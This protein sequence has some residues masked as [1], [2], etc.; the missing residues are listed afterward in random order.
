M[1]NKQVKRWAQGFLVFVLVVTG[2]API[3]GLSSIAY[4][5]E[6]S[7]VTE[8]PQTS[9]K[10]TS[11]PD[12]VPTEES[13]DLESPTHEDDDM[14]ETKSE[15]PAETDN[16]EVQEADGTGIISIADARVLSPN[17]NVAVSGVVTYSEL[18]GEFT[19][20]YIQDEEAGIVVRAKNQ[21]DVG[22]RIEV[23]GPITHYSGLVQ[24][25]KDKS[26]F[27]E[28]Y[29]KVTEQNVT[30]PGPKNMV[31][32]DFVRPAD[33]SNKGPGEKYEGMFVE[34]RDIQVTRGSSSTFYA[35]DSHGAESAKPTNMC[36]VFSRSIQTM[37]W[38]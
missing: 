1:N 26:G 4:A 29:M 32:T 24:I 14:D 27:T 30:L 10:E 16:A 2:A 21:V 38:N 15:E 7:V 33:Q 13:S 11:T 5:D 31:S 6:E 3:G 12:A 23:Y 18:S 35:T 22:D 9:D 8:Q 19:N 25:E 36:R 28:G 37:V 17:T 34:V 20:Y